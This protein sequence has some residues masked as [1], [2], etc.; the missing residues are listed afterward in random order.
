MIRDDEL[1][2]APEA[3]RGG[4]YEMWQEEGELYLMFILTSEHFLLVLK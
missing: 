1:A 3:P 4:C 2:Q